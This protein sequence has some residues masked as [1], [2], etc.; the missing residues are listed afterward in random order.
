MRISV[1]REG[2]VLGLRWAA[3]VTDDDVKVSVNGV[4]GEPLP[5]TSGQRDTLEALVDRVVEA[6]V[7]RRAPKFSVPDGMQTVL[8]V[9]KDGRRRRLR[10]YSGAKAADEIW[11]LIGT[12]SEVAQP[13]G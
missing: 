3:R 1:Q 7:P 5:L 6:P 10:L 8:E 9:Q 13:T 4:A 2:G 11:E 12:V